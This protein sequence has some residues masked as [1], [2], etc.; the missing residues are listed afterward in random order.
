VASTLDAGG[1]H[2]VARL[3]GGTTGVVIEVRGLTS[4]VQP[5]AHLT[6]A[7][8]LA[9]EPRSPPTEVRI[10]GQTMWVRAAPD[11]AWTTVDAAASAA[12][13]STPPSW[14]ELFRSLAARPDA[15]RWRRPGRQLVTIVDG[16]PATVDFD[17]SGHIRALRI[18]KGGGV[19]FELELSD[20]GTDVVVAPP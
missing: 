11:A 12:T 4:F 5:L 15:A 1:G 17:P 7:T 2:I 6:T 18:E 3:S 14:A 9:G 10:R 20:L 8:G 13:G 16:R 19:V